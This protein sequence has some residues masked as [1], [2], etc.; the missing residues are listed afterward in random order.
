MKKYFLMLLVLINIIMI[1]TNAFALDTPQEYKSGD[2]IYTYLKDDTAEII[3][4]LGT[5][6]NIIIPSTVN[7]IIVTSIDNI[8]FNDPDTVSSITIPGSVVSV[9]AN[10]FAVCTKLKNISVSADHPTLTTIDGV[11]FSKEDS[12]LVC[13]PSAFLEGTYSFLTL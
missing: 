2:F 10:P 9:K 8:V 7:G 5:D 4:Y 3:K 6:N 11:L 12:C 13:Y 1:S